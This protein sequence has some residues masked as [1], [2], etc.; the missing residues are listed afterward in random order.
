MVLL[1]KY[2]Y[3]YWDCHLFGIAVLG[4]PLVDDTDSLHQPHLKNENK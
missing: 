3:T 4:R 1:N 2:F